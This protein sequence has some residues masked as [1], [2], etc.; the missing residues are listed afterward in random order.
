MRCAFPPEIN[1]TRTRA[2]TK[3]SS[4][5]LTVA[6]RRQ[7]SHVRIVSGAPV[8]QRDMRSRT[9]TP[10]LSY[11][12]ESAISGENR[13]PGQIAWQLTMAVRSSNNHCFHK[14]QEQNSKG[15]RLGARS[16]P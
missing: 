2:V 7:R 15:G 11:L 16:A 9:E 12:S 14:W 10:V 1:A 3:R 4:A 13:R 5:R 8:F 6:L